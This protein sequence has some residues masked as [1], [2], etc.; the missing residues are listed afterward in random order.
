MKT[1]PK[2]FKIPYN[3]VFSNEN[4]IIYA[5]LKP[6]NNYPLTNVDGEIDVANFHE[7]VKDAIEA[8]SN[9]CEQYSF[10]IAGALNFLADALKGIAEIY[11]YTTSTERCVVI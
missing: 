6:I 9:V 2:G 5:L 8:K 7:C 1:V 10:S 3:F 11:D 4:I